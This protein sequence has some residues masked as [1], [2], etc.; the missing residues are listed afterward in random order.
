MTTIAYKD[1]VL[2]SDTGSSIGRMY[3]GK[4]NKI[5]QAKDGM[6]CGLAGRILDASLLQEWMF[7]GADR[8]NLP[9]FEDED[10]EGIIVTDG[11]LEYITSKGI[12]SI[13]APYYAE[14]TGYLIAMGAMAQGATAE[15]AVEIAIRL[16]EC[17]YAPIQVFK[18]KS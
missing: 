12:F 1:G 14:G 5:A 16:D 17:T 3:A 6:M 11:K 9:D 7:N 15:R 10:A 13:D 8:D 2:A 4:V 18:V